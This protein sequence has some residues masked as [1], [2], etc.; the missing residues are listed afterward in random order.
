MRAHSRSQAR[1]LWLKMIRRSPI[2]AAAIRQQPSPSTAIP[3]INPS[4]AAL[5]ELPGGLVRSPS[6]SSQIET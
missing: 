4:S 5:S 3:I 6:R 1:V 2:H